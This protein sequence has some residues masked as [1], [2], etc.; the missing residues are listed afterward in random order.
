MLTIVKM[1]DHQ[2]EYQFS[3]LDL[4]NENICHTHYLSAVLSNRNP[5]F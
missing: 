3:L 2:L 1:T 5:R 4:I